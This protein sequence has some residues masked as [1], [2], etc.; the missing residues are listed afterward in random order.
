[1]KL[2]QIRDQLNK[3]DN[4]LYGQKNIEDSVAMLY[5]E[6]SK[7]NT[8]TL[9][10]FRET[11]GTFNN[12]FITERWSQPYK[13]YPDRKRIDLSVYTE[14][15]HSGDLFGLLA[16]RRSTRNYDK[17]HCMSVGDL[18]TILYNAY[19]VTRREKIN[20]LPYEAHMGFRNIPSAGGLYPL[21]L[22]VVTF[23][24]DIPQGLYHYRPD[25]NCLEELIKADHR[26]V[27]KDIILAAPY[28]N[29]NAASAMIITTGLIE[30]VIIKYSDRGYRFMMQ[31]SGA[32]GLM[33]SLLAESV[34]LGTCSI[35]AY[36]DDLLNDFLSID[37]VFESVNNVIII[38]GKVG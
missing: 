27:L 9:R 28:V 22:Y 4:S 15:A 34:N 8:H 2:S 38:G 26:P 30:R 23:N 12:G 21:E 18:A 36:N 14:T 20:G 37:G 35:G 1:M 7:F 3:L 25:L 10:R 6:N 33:V 32:V 11:S 24:A 29:L 17:D 16:N 13:C 5:H 31:E 19:G